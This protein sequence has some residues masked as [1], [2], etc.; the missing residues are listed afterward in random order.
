M[1][2]LTVLRYAYV[3]DILERRGPHREEHLALL[4][5]AADR[6]EARLGGAVGDPP[7]GGLIVFTTPEAAAAFVAADPYVA[8][9]LVTSH[10]VEPWTVVV[11]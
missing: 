11:P 1:E 4:R 3:P 5:A 10:E 6:G 8:N 7:H 2:Q 9:G